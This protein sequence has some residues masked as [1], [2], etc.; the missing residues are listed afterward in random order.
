M[1]SIGKV[2]HGSF[3]RASVYNAT[4]S[5]A[6]NYGS[7]LL[8]PRL[9]ESDYQTLCPKQSLPACAGQNLVRILHTGYWSP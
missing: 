9:A 1:L 2:S 8:E 7:Y 6:S 3:P 4:Y 5:L